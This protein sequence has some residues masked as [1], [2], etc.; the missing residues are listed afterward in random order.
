MWYKFDKEEL[1]STHL[2][3]E[4]V[5]FIDHKNTFIFSCD[6]KN[7]FYHII[8]DGTAYTCRLVNNFYSLLKDK[9]IKKR[10]EKYVI[11]KCNVAYTDESEYIDWFRSN[12]Y[13]ILD[14]DRVLYHFYINSEDFTVE[15]ITDEIPTVKRVEVNMESDITPY[16]KP[17][18]G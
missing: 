8:V 16:D 13:P 2:Y 1:N 4:N 11:R 6:T 9:Y 14:D 17:Y 15:F 7:E 10:D 5:T 12:S 3:F 18:I